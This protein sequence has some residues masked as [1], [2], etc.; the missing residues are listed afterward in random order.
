MYYLNPPFLVSGT[1]Q[2]LTAITAGLFFTPI[3]CENR[4]DRRKLA[5]FGRAFEGRLTAGQTRTQEAE[6][7]LANQQISI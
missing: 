2:Q 3:L 4:V 1:L 7:N 6:T 5:T